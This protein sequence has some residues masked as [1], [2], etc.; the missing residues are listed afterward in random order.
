[1]AL[2][3][4][5]AAA[6][7]LLAAARA[8]AQVVTIAETL[9][10]GKTGLLVTDNVIVPGE[11]IPNLNIAYVEFA[12][13]LTER[14]DL[15]LAAGETTTDGSTQAWLGG[16][17]NLRLARIRKLT[18]SLFNVASVPL[19]HRDQACLVL[20]NPAIVASVPLNATLTVYSGLNSL[21]P[22]GERERGIFTPPSAKV[23]VPIGAAV[24]LGAWGIWGEADLGTLNA[25]GVGVTRIW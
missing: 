22:I 5:L 3:R 23:N 24:A 10:K 25:V 6:F 12:R 4:A 21:V 11:R 18:L 14:F 15:Y 7:L 8:D 9:G 16:G 1:V 2:S 13:G 17:G 19:N 20:W